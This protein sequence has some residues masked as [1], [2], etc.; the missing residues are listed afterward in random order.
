MEKQK[1]TNWIWFIEIWY[2]RLFC[3]LF[4]IFIVVVSISDC[5][6][7]W[8]GVEWCECSCSRCCC[9]CCCRYAI[10]G[11][12][13]KF[14]LKMNSQCYQMLHCFQNT[15]THTHT[16]HAI[17]AY[18]QICTLTLLQ[19][20]ETKEPLYTVRSWSEEKVHGVYFAW[21]E[22]IQT[23]GKIFPFP[24]GRNNKSANYT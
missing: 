18:I 15:D 5:G 9:C 21:H 22:E 20:V 3:C 1:R 7:D 2:F 24:L 6:L 23:F 12:V 11:A 10:V 8:S 19:I 16:R 17:H 4:L 14:S 13:A